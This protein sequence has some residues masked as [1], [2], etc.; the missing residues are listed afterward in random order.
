MVIYSH[1]RLTT[2]EQCP[3]KYK[4]KY[5]DKIITLEKSI[6]T[7]LGKMVHDTLEWLY[8][9]VANNKIPTIDEIITHYTN[10]WG[11]NHTP[12]LTIIKK[13]FT[14]KEFNSFLIITCDTN[15]LMTIP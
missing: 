6:E 5:I 1:S 13:E 2:F 4:Y 15:H 11:K 12:S 9:Q 3:L 7:F 8:T 10:N 14:T